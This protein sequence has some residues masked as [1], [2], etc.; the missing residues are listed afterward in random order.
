[1]I[2]KPRVHPGDTG[3]SASPREATLHRVVAERVRRRLMSGSSSP[4]VVDTSRGAF[5][6]KLRGAGHGLHALAAEL[7][8][9]DLAERIGLPVPER[10]LLELPPDVASDDRN[11]ELAQLLTAST[12]LNVGFRFMEGAKVPRAEALA[13]LD[14][15]FV[16]R[17]LCL[18][19]LVMNLDRTSSNPNLLFW[20]RQPWLIDHGTALP[21]HYRWAA[22]TEQ[23]PHE[24]SDYTQHVFGA[25]RELL[26]RFDPQLAALV[27]RAALQTALARVPDEF[28]IATG[29][30]P[31]PARSRAAYVAFLWKRLKA[32]RPFVPSSPLPTST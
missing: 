11:D 28:L 29:P 12:G 23:T 19:G 3:S 24:P 21:F 16:A 15:E 8:V 9:A 6:A 7:V 14:D 17:V 2:G 1:M 30:S 10:V 18:D 13:A 31:S 27:D 4:I 20:K 25:R 26:A 5:V 32:P 22:V